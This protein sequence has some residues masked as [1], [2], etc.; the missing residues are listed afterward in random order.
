MPDTPPDPCAVRLPG[1]GTRLDL[2]D[3]EGRPVHVVSRNDGI[4]E[5]H[6]GNDHIIELD[7][8]TAH[9]VGAF[10]TGHYVLGPAV[11]GRMSDVLGGLLFDWVTLPADAHAVGKTIEALAIRRKTRVSIIAILRASQPI[12]SP[13]PQTV[14]EAGDDLVVACREQDLEVF[15]RYVLTGK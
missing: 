2:S 8:A 11:A 10:V 15:T 6:H 14:L 5:L 13:D 3:A 9:A 12:V 4:V 7:A 1:I